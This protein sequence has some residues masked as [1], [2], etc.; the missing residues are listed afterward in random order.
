MEFV[1]TIH[2]FKFPHIESPS[3]KDDAL[4]FLELYPKPKERI[5]PYWTDPIK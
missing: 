5:I 1:I 2:V 3:S 4:N